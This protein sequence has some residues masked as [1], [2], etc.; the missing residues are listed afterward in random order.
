MD[1]KTISALAMIAIAGCAHAE[2][3]EILTTKSGMTVYTFDSDST[4][5]SNCHDQCLAI[6]PAVSPAD[7]SGASVGKMTRSDGKS[8]ATFNGK[9]IYLFAGDTRP[10][11]ANGDNAQNVWHVVRL[12]VSGRL[13]E[14][15][16]SYSGYGY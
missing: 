14:S 15:E 11:D 16:R 3:G 9:P 4:G 5:K 2:T 12:G 8:Q 7:I 6:W 13:S 10:G 1:A